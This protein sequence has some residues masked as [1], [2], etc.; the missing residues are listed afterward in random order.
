MSAIQMYY[1]YEIA[2][3]KKNKSHLTCCCAI[4]IHDLLVKSNLHTFKYY[5]GPENSLCRTCWSKKYFNAAGITSK[6][7]LAL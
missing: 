6:E 2:K 7:D 1:N 5:N 4:F 3:R